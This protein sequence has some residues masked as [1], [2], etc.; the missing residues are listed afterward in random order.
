MSPHRPLPGRTPR[1]VLRRRLHRVFGRHG[2]RS[3]SPGCR[4]RAFPHPADAGAPARLRTYRGIGIA[5]VARSRDPAWMDRNLPAGL[6]TA[7]L[8]RHAGRALQGLLDLRF[9]PPY[10]LDRTGHR[11]RGRTVRRLDPDGRR[12]PRNGPLPELSATSSRSH[13]ARDTGSTA[14]RPCRSIRSRR[15]TSPTLAATSRNR[16]TSRSASSTSSR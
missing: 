15:W 16:R 8:A 14:T 7:A 4:H 3:L 13:R 12:R 1:G 6:R 11:S 9:R 5:G 10:R 2:G